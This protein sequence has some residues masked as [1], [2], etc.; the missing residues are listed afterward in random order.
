MKGLEII[1]QFGVQIFGC[2]AECKKNPDLFFKALAEAG[3]K[4]IEPCILFDDPVKMVENARVTGNEFMERLADN[5]WK[6]EEVPEY[7]QLMEKYGLKL[8]SVH[9]F[10]NNMNQVADKMIETAKKNKISSYIV[11]CNQQ[12]IVTDYDA[13]A[14]DCC[15]LSATLRDYGIDLWIHNNGVEIKTR[16]EHNGK[17]VPILSAI[18]DLCKNAKVGAQID[19]GWVLYGGIDPVKYLNEVKEYVRS[20][21]FKDLKKDFAIRSDGDIFACLGDGALKVKEILECVPLNSDITVLID[22][23]ASDGD[24]MEDMRKSYQVLYEAFQ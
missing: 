8:S 20:I 6:P 24:I 11:N 1:M 13:F 12:T 22:Q 16:V 23:D 18:L 17:Q 21:H 4:Q 3:Y 5:I 7:I 10:A 14:S 19:V 9:V 2:L 15:N